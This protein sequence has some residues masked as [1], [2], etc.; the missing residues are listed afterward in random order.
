MAQDVLVAPEVLQEYTRDVFLRLGLPGTHAQAAAA[1]LIWANLRGVETH[2]VRNLKLIYVPM[3]EQELIRTD[4]RYAIEHETPF[5]ARVDGDCG[6]GMA[7]GVWA[8][9]LAIEKARQSGIGIVAMR[10]SHHYG[11]AGYYASLALPHDMLGISLTGRFMPRGERIGIVPTFAAVPM[12]STNPIAFAAP[13]MHEA[14][15]VLDMATSITPYNRVMLHDEIGLDAPLGWGLDDEGRPTTDPSRLH[16]LLP[17]GGTREMGSHKGYGLAMVVEILSSVLSGGWFDGVD[18]DKPTYDGHG[19]T[20][21]GHF[22]GAIR[23]TP[24]GRQMN[25]NA[26]WM[27]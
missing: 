12:F 5:S 7:A 20:G 15:Y 24:F 9:Q 21:D 23:M 6:L 27:P 2:G 16:Q 14:P 19:Q 11:A 22:F 26:G 8:M 1:V 3:I 13:T 10:N 17:L 18:D 4:A 25:S